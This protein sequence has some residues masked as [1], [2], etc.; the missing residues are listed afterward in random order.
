MGGEIGERIEWAE[1]M[2]DLKSK[3]TKGVFWNLCER[4][5]SQAV[6]FV[7]SIV[8]ARLLTPSAYGVVALTTI[9]IN[10]CRFLIDSGFAASLIQKKNVQPI[11]YDSVFYFNI[12]TSA[13]LYGVLFV[14]APH[15]AE[16]YHEPQLCT[17][18]RVIAISI[19]LMAVNAVQ[20][21]V[22]TKEMRFNL[23]FRLNLVKC[24][25]QPCIGIPM[26]Y[27][28]YGVWALVVSELAS[29][30]LTV[31]FTW[32]WIGWRPHLAF[33]FG[34]LKGLMSFGWKIFASGLFAIFYNNFYDVMVG[35]FYTAADLAL[36]NKGRTFPTMAMSSI[37]SSIFSVVFPA[38]SSIQDNT[39]QL[40]HTMRKM[41]RIA[42]VAT[43]PALAL[44]AGCATPL[45]HAVLG[46]KW[47]AAAPYVQL[48]C[49]VYFLF[50]L[51]AITT[52]ATKAVGR[53]DVVLYK[54]ILFGIANIVVIV[55]CHRLGA[56]A[57]AIG[58]SIAV[59]P[60]VQFVH[61][62]FNRFVLD[63][64]LRDQMK[65]VFPMVFVAFLTYGALLVFGRYCSMF[66]PWAQLVVQG[67][68]GFVFAVAIMVLL[69]PKGLKELFES[70]RN[71]SSRFVARFQHWFCRQG[72]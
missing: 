41:V 60:F 57:M 49:L 48:G 55:A 36:Y 56:L 32:F 69:R 37:D 17:V 24:I 3:V 30:F 64:S 23:S 38:F 8:L 25:S 16:F 46:E 26:A 61:A 21:S 2:N 31:M 4:F 42:N 40:M 68:S 71:T 52:Q 27:C 22:M 34:A 12:V 67:F 44:I 10:A 15:I 72:D 63:Y 13:L 66:S 11:D 70:W 20:L 33:S 35:R 14:L 62:V 6:G 51:G 19:L 54:S 59:G 47:L 58:I 9:F 53:S 1:Q 29:S 50:P 7:V 28:G 43:M 39:E 65:D 45:V 5:S 18:L